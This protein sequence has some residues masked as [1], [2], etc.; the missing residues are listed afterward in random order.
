MTFSLDL[1]LRV[2]TLTGDW[3]GSLA[4]LLQV[5][6]DNPKP[7][8]ADASALT[9]FWAMTKAHLRRRALLQ[10]ARIKRVSAKVKL[11]LLTSPPVDDEG[12]PIRMTKENLEVW[13]LTEPDIET[14]AEDLLHT[15][16]LLEIAE[17]AMW[18][19]K[20]FH[21]D[22]QVLS[23]AHSQER[24]VPQSAPESHDPGR[25]ANRVANRNGYKDRSHRL[26]DNLGDNHGGTTDNAEED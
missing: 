26:E 11:R 21:K 15:E 22:I 3:E 20:M 25:R 2:P 9:M 13:L 8:M 19:C 17:S 7:S 23:E 14:A 18:E 4:Q 24:S 10:Q 16:M 5:D 1:R 6:V 12:K